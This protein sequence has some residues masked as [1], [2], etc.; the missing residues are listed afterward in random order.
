MSTYKGEFSPCE[1][2]QVLDKSSISYVIVTRFWLNGLL[3]L[4]QD[5]LVVKVQDE[6]FCPNHMGESRKSL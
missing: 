4:G 2:K 6:D 5:N 3:K 1:I